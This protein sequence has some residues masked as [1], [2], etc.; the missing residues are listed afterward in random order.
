MKT[1]IAILAAAVL[2][3]SAVASA[4]ASAAD[5][6]I[7]G[8]QRSTGTIFVLS[9]YDAG[10]VSMARQAYGET[11][12]GTVEDAVD[13]FFVDHQASIKPDMLAAMNAD[14]GRSF[15]GEYAG[16]PATIL[17]ALAGDHLSFVFI[18]S[19]G[20][21]TDAIA[22]AIA[23]WMYGVANGGAFPDMMRGWSIEVTDGTDPDEDV[24]NLI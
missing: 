13:G 4:G 3:F 24:P 8:T 18:A 12:R 10:S 22:D 20:Y 5:V 1:F 15:V 19:A 6:D 7:T 11:G 14:A 21:D 9:W 16:V 17:I 2:S 23:Y